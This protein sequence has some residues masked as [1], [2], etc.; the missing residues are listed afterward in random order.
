MLIVFGMIISA[1]ATLNYNTDTSYATLVNWTDASS[2][3]IDPTENG[4]D[5]TNSGATINTGSFYADCDGSLDYLFTGDIDIVRP[6]SI[7]F[8]VQQ[9]VAEADKDIISKYESGTE[10][11]LTFSSNTD[12]DFRTL[13]TDGGS[14]YDQ[15]IMYLNAAQFY[16]YMITDDGVTTKLYINGTFNSSSAS[17]GDI[18]NTGDWEFCSSG[19]GSTRR[20]NGKITQFYIFNK[21]LD[22]TE[23]T[24]HYNN[25]IGN[26]SFNPFALK[27]T[28]EIISD[29]QPFYN[30]SNITINVN[31]SSD[32]NM[33]YILDD[34]DLIVSNGLVAYYQAE[35][36]ANDRLGLNNGTWSGTEAY[37][38][39]VNYTYGNAF[40]F[41][42]TNWITINALNINGNGTVCTWFRFDDTFVS[43]SYIFDNRGDNGLG[44]IRVISPNDIGVSNGD[45]YI[46]GV[47][48]SD[49]NLGEWNHLCITNF[50]ILSIDGGF[51]EIPQLGR[52]YSN[53]DYFNG[54]IDEV[55]IYNRSLN[56]SEIT[57]LYETSPYANICENC[58]S[59][60]FN[61]TDLSEE[62]HNIKL[63]S[64]N[65]FGMETVFENF[66]IDT[67]APSLSVNL[68]AEYGFY[69]GFNFSQYINIS[70]TNL[71]SCIVSIGGV[72]VTTCS[73]Q[74]YNFTANGDKNVSVTAID[75]AG[76][77]NTSTN[78]IMLVNPLQ[79]WNFF[80][81]SN[82]TAITNYT[83]GGEDFNNNPAC[84]DTYNDG[85]ILGQNT[86]TF[87]KLGFATTQV[88]FNLSITSN[89]NQSV[90]ITQSKIILRI[91]DRETEALVT[92][93]STITLIATQGFSGTTTTGEINISN[94]N[95]LAEQYQIIVTHTDY[96]T[97]TIYFTYNNQ[98]NLVK[99]VYLLKSNSSNLGMITLQ[100]ETDTAQFV[101]SALCIASE[102]DSNLSG[103]RDIAEGLTNVNGQT[104]LNIELNVKSYK[105]TCSK[106]GFSST[107]N[108]QII[109][110]DDTLLPLVL[111]ITT[112]VRPDN[113][114]GGISGNLT[115]V[116][117][118]ATHDL[119]TYKWFDEFNLDNTG[120]LAV[121][122]VVGTRRTLIGTAQTSASNP[123]ELFVIVDVNSTSRI[124]VVGSIVEVSGG[125]VV[126]DSITYLPS[127]DI[128]FGLAEYGFDL[129]IPT[130]FIIIGIVIGLVLKPQNIYIS[131]MSV[132]V[133]VWLSVLIVPGVISALVATFVTGISG[134]ILYGGKR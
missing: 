78:N 27:F 43:S 22:P 23:V 24:F 50:T 95:F 125:E 77:T 41:D 12:W 62:L 65:E 131:T 85:I 11:F 82:A 19:L 128:S 3:L 73:E 80:V 89:I 119:V 76:N 107:T 28:P 113:V 30:S 121:Y 47:S 9:D 6:Y 39:S 45:G 124:E 58:N 66:T 29:I 86:L 96:L 21:A 59:S 53:I 55:R 1:N 126:I 92:G 26:F 112:G 7:S 103:Y 129:L 109:Q 90:N 83:F 71:L 134:F 127:S 46:N 49:F 122:K 97:E 20:L 117:W 64:Q 69:D 48:T 14:D 31:T 114:Y 72:P 10:R 56:I 33:T 100:V 115:N 36:N 8:I 133:M 87:E 17:V 35:N 16:E 94:I 98:E 57:Q 108:S 52:R 91:F 99:E 118:N 130:L 44:Y 67:I 132:I 104:S 18:N 4:F 79:C 15:S 74:N 63:I 25:N 106:S 2:A 60:S 102:W 32:V 40:D 51:G 37:S 123:G 84:F 38:S 111:V 116:S 93:T 13:I 70:D 54:S 101:E 5:L 42:E 105:F 120:K 81:E 61:L 88:S 75:L 34:D 68:P 110:T